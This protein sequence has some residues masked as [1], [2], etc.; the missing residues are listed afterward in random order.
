MNLVNFDLDT[1]RTLI[2]ASDLGGYGQAASRLGRTPSAISLQMKKLQEDAGAT[3][4]RKQGRGIALTEAGE[5]V[6]RYGRKMLALNDELLD[7]V[8]GASLAGTIRLGFS[9]DF[10]DTVLPTVLSQF[11]KLYPLV[12]MEVRIEG[13]AA[14]VE[15]IE[16]DQ[17]DLALAVG[18]ADR[19]TAQVLG[20]IELVWI[21]G[22]EFAKR[23]G[24]QL[25][26]V[27]LGPQCAFRKEAI[28]KLDQAGVPWRIAAVSPSLAGLWASAIGGL[29][30]TVRSSLGLPAKLVWDKAMFDLPKLSSFPVTLHT[31]QK[32]MSA[33]VERLYAIVSEAVSRQLPTMTG[34]KS[35]K[36]R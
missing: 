31:Q 11:T 1:L 33:G 4:F 18:Q 23:E 32:V 15:A 25:P 19:P 28:L 9:Q 5:I 24:Q 27:L 35:R 3:L 30:I 10:A 36:P 2:V 16:K 14:L 34:K 8:Q 22:Q 29:G 12:Q 13:N 17:L 6:L 20:N 7:T 21:A 26:L